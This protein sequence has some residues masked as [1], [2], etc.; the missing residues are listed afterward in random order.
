MKMLQNPFVL[1]V[2]GLLA[3]PGTGLWLFAQRLDTLAAVVVAARARAAEAAQP[4]EPWGFWSIELENL[5]AELK[6]EKAHLQQREEALDQREARFAS[7]QAE[8]S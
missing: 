4:P 8:L 2:L 1:I 6:D 3:G 5:S 7:E